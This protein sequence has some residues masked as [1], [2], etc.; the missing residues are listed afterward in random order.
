MEPGR[1]DLY[2]LCSRDTPRDRGWFAVRGRGRIP[3]AYPPNT[4]VGQWAAGYLSGDGKHLLI[5]WTAECETPFAFVVS[6][7]G[8]QPRLVL[9][10]SRLERAQPS[11]AHGWTLDG[12]MIIEVVPGC[13]APRAKSR[14]RLIEP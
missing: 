10:G 5:Q 2:L 7:A 9:G 1:N 8:G 13:G 12:R 11:F 14:L 6:R 4:T 3:I